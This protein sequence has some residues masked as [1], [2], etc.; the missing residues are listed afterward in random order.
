MEKSRNVQVEN[1]MGIRHK[2]EECMA[3]YKNNKGYL[4]DTD[5]NGEDL[6]ILCDE[7]KNIIK[8][9]LNMDFPDDADIQLSNA[10]KAVFHSWNGERA[11]SYR[12][13]ENILDTAGT[14]VNIQSMVFGNM[15]AGSATGVA[16]T[17]NPSTP[18][19][20]YYHQWK[21]YA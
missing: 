11:Q 13:I 12:K 14:A 6:K 2:L 17:R 8:K 3:N 19:R 1:N 15:G 18:H 4:E 20:T 5:L 7:F 9:T 21:D 16:F 10:I